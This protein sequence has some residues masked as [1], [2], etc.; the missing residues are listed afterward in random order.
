MCFFFTL[1]LFGPRVA[2]ILWWIISPLRFDVIF[3]SWIWPVLG[4]I[5]LPWTTLMYITVGLNGIDGFD[6]FWLGL[7]FLG[8]LASYATS[9]YA[10]RDKIPGT[11][12]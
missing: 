3:D 5:F 4:I 8:D 7:A 12:F 11:Q 10:N 2:T 9:G 6:W 1:L